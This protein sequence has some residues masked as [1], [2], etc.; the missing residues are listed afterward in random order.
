M[1]DWLALVPLLLFGVALWA[2]VR[3]ETRKFRLAAG[4]A[5][6]VI[7]GVLLLGARDLVIQKIIG[8]LVMPAGLLF[9]GLGA[10]VVILFAR[11][12]KKLGA[13]AAIIFAAYSLAGNTVVATAV[14]NL[15]EDDFPFTPIAEVEEVDALLV[16]GGGAT[17]PPEGE[18]KLNE[19]GDRVMHAARLYFAG[20]TKILVTSG[21]AI[22]G[23]QFPQDLSEAT[24]QIWTDLKI[25]EENIL[26]LPEPKNTSQEITAFK[27]LA[28]ERGF[29]KVGVLSSAWHLARAKALADAAGL[30]AVFVAADRRGGSLMFN[31]AGLIPQ[32]GALKTTQNAL[33]ELLGRAVGR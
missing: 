2:R 14:T 27:A 10:L 18:A 25:P 33:W 7:A 12:E 26:R 8:Y 1:L 21:S 19:H 11:R 30:S 31:A 22:A 13:F 9:L 23:I 16:L 15:L 20:K 29:R 3:G 6:A 32:P 17:L 24:R 28:A 4:S 5:I